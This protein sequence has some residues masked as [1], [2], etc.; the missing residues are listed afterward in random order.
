VRILL[1]NE[2]VFWIT[3]VSG[4]VRSW[5]RAGIFFKV[6][7]VSSLRGI[8]EMLRDLAVISLVLPRLS[9]IYA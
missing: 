8:N 6:L 4:S 7:L 5:D 1:G 2:C 9:L 3:F